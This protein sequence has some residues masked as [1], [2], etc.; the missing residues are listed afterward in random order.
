M[1]PSDDRRPPMARQWVPP[2]KQ[3]LQRRSSRG[4]TEGVPYFDQNQT[5]LRRDIPRQADA[6]LSLDDGQSHRVLPVLA[7]AVP[8]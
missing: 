2:R 6:L 7:H 1:S 3:G 4:S 8:R 5:T